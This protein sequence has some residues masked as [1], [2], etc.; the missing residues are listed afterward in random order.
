MLIFN[1][2]QEWFDFNSTVFN[3]FNENKKKKKK[4]E[5]LVEKQKHERRKGYENVHETVNN[6]SWVEPGRREKN[7][8]FSPVSQDSHESSSWE[9]KK[10]EKCTEKTSLS[11]IKLPPFSFCK[12]RTSPS[13]EIEI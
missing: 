6:L 13:V 1:I 9:Q 12:L 5:K 7:T 11:R 2:E 10:S 8:L 4:Y 3:Y